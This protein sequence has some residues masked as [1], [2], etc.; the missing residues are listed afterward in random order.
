MN[1]G[2][3]SS[4]EIEERAGAWLSKRESGH[5]SAE[6]QAHLTQWLNACTANRVAYLRQEAAWEYALRL[7]ALKGNTPRG[8]IPSPEDWRLS[9]FFS[10]GHSA[11]AP[12][13]ARIDP[14]PNA[15]EVRALRDVMRGKPSLK[16][17]AFAASVLLAIAASIAWY[18]W[19]QDP[20]YRTPIGV[21]AA[22]PLPD[23]SK[24]TL[25][26]DSE[27]HVAVTK[28]ERRIEL[29]KGEA[30][31][32]VAKD[33]T[34]PFIVTVGNRHV[35][36]VGTA[37]SVRREGNDI[38]VLV[39][40]GKVRI[41]DDTFSSSKSNP[42]PVTAGGI[43]RAG[44]AGIIVQQNSLPEIEDYLS[45][46]AG[47]LIFRETPLADAISEFNRY[48]E[49]KILIQDPAIAAIRFSGKI[50]PTS[51]E[52]FIRL[53]EDSFLIRAQRADGKILLTAAN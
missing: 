5:W 43:A 32:N 35:I 48:N 1:M 37:F 4:I 34:R 16:R 44:D 33:P 41:E 51:F 53:L 19:S 21:T 8:E 24:I 6:D 28:K 12:P 40:E 11:I 39:T 36:A 15:R 22:V 30:F 9:P 23:G 10:D 47:Y 46:R 27:I 25:N 45:W 26:T 3:E 29:N 2:M 38:H 31:F 50:H 17:F 13:F 42:V 52:P 14:N 18:S 20:S 7:Q 49:Q